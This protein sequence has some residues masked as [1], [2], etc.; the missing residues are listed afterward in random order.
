MSLNALKREVELLHRVLSP[1]PKYDVERASEIVELLR[2][3]KEATNQFMAELAA[4]GLAPQQ[5]VAELYRAV[6]AITNEV[7]DQ[8]TREESQLRKQSL[9]EM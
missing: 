3:Q 9:R 2:L 6:Q 7:V 4:Q 1:E 8:Y 5:V